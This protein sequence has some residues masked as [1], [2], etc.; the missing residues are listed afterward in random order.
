MF[1]IITSRDFLAKL[2][3]DLDEFMKETHSTRLPLNC[4]MTA[5]HLHEWVRGD[6]LKTDHATWKALKIRDKDSF[7]A[8]IET[9]CPGFTTIQ[10]LTN[11]TKHFAV[12]RGQWLCQ[13]EKHQEQL[14]EG[15]P[16]THPR[17]L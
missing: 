5:Y 6:W 12:G 16:D 7:I 2:E 11:G 17:S 4:A 13:R 3:A 8:C 14:R 10:Q 1:D 15:R 9:A